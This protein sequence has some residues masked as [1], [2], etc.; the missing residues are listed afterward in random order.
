M[1]CSQDAYEDRDRIGTLDCGHEYHAECLKKWLLVKNI[2]P[3]CKSE[4]LPG[5]RKD[6]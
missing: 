2:C 5:K 4:A 3:V 1:L 6:L